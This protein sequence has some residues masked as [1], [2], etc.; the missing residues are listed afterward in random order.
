VCT[1]IN[2][3]TYLYIHVHT[4]MYIHADVGTQPVHA[5]C[6]C[7]GILC[8]FIYI[9]SYIQC[10]CTYI[11]IYSHIIIYIYIYT[12]RHW[13]RVNPQRV[14]LP[15]HIMYMYIHTCIS[16]I[17]VHIHIYTYIYTHT[18]THI[19][20]Y[21]HRRW[22]TANPCRVL[23]PWRPVGYCAG[24]ISQKSARYSSYSIKWLQGW[25]LRI[26]ANCLLWSG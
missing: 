25:L 17:C 10:K 6:Y 9:H 16:L 5:G 1:Y 2:I 21:T 8:I 18:Y 12:Y 22:H 19:H 24:D 23:L 15:W 7:H 13:H 11:Y 3:L 26:F 14:L 20:I 4:Y